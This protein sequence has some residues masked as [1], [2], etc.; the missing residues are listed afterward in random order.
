MILALVTSLTA[1]NHDLIGISCNGRIQFS[2]IRKEQPSSYAVVVVPKHRDGKQK[3]GYLLLGDR[4]IVDFGRF[5]GQKIILVLL[6]RAAA[7]QCTA[8]MSIF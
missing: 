7:E 8:G 4:G 3:W 1:K 2:L 5:A 6:I